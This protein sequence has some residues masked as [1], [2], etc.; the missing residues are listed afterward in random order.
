MND[1]MAAEPAYELRSSVK[2]APGFTLLEA[3]IGLAISAMIATVLIQVLRQTYLTGTAATATTLRTLGS[4]LDQQRVATALSSVL[5]PYPDEEPSLVGTEDEVTFY[6]PATA[7]GHRSPAQRWRMRI[8]KGET[9]AS[10]L[11]DLSANPTTAILPGKT[12]TFSYLGQSLDWY[13]SWP[14]ANMTSDYRVP[15][16]VAITIVTPA[17][18]DRWIF[19]VGGDVTLQPRVQDML[20]SGMP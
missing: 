10:L 6:A 9:N 19:A 17:G 3:L 18:E 5:A 7:A 13:D 11:L 2:A 16:A 12:A 20:Q 4:L 8:E 1:P 14:P 15:E